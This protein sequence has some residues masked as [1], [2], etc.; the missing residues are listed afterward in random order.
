MNSLLTLLMEQ[1]WNP[2]SVTGTRKR[3]ELFKVKEYLDNNY[4]KKIT[5]DELASIFYIDKFYLAKT[6]KAM[7]G[8]TIS[9]Y[10]I[11]KRVTRAKQLLRFSDLTIEEV[12]MDVGAD[13]GCYFSRMFRRVEGITPGEYRKQW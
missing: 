7:Y 2:D 4:T 12:G 11:T 9:N 10:L 8:T 5:L 6:F 3:S 1:S 13:N